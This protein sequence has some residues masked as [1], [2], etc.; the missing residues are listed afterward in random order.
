[1]VV[2][3]TDSVGVILTSCAALCVLSRLAGRYE[4]G[5]YALDLVPSKG[6]FLPCMYGGFKCCCAI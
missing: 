3:G 4:Q 5:H 6:K 1:M 2:F